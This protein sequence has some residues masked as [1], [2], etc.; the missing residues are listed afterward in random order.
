[1]NHF[2]LI[3]G[4]GAETLPTKWKLTENT[5]NEYKYFLSLSGLCF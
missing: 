3:K 4:N 2:L 5:Q 1:M